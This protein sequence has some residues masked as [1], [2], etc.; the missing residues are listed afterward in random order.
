MGA[1]GLPL[2]PHLATKVRELVVKEKKKIPET[3]T[4]FCLN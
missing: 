3:L 2:L 4:T 1:E